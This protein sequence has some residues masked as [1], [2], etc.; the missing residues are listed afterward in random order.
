[1]VSVESHETPLRERGPSQSNPAPAL[2]PAFE[3]E[4]KA[5]VLFRPGPR[6]SFVGPAPTG[7]RGF[8]AQHHGHQ[9]IC[10]LRRIHPCLRMRVRLRRALAARLSALQC[11][12]RAVCTT[13]QQGRFKE[14]EETQRPSGP[15]EAIRS[16]TY[17]GPQDR[18]AST[19]LEFTSKYDEFFRITKLMGWVSAVNYERPFAKSSNQS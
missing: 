17:T 6:A 7:G 19:G 1:M 4:S 15:S 2:S 10:E 13:R 14:E 3:P 16:S 11:L 9:G 12:A 18:A 8:S 5:R